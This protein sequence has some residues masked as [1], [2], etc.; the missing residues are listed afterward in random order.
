[1]KVINM[2]TETVMLCPADRTSRGNISL[3]TSQPKGPQDHAKP[4]TYVQTKNNTEAVNAFEGFAAFPLVP[5]MTAIKVPTMVCN[6]REETGESVSTGMY[7]CAIY[8][9]VSVKKFQDMREI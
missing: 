5:N 8:E 1:M 7:K 9:M 6:T 3:G 2:L 4:A